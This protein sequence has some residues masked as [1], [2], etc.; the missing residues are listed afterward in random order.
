M[1]F[2][3]QYGRKER[4]SIEYTK[5]LGE[6]F[7]DSGVKKAML[8]GIVPNVQENYMNIKTVQLTPVAGVM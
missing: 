6:I 3:V 4:R 8:I 7:V 2:C 1:S 5:R